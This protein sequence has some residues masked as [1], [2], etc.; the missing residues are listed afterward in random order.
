MKIKIALLFV[1]TTTCFAVESNDVKA[2][3]LQFQEKGLLQGTD[4]KQANK[5]LDNITPEQWAQ[6]NALVNSYGSDQ[7]RMPASNDINEASQRV[8]TESKEFKD[9]SNKLRLI[10]SQ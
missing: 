5:N 8:N 6:I 1:L 10:L 7:H 9:I 2:M 3:M 4:I